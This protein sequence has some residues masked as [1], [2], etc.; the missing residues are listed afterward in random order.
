VQ[1]VFV[2]IEEDAGSDVR[3]YRTLYGIYKDQRLPCGI[4]LSYP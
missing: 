1:A 4:P 2:V 3:Q